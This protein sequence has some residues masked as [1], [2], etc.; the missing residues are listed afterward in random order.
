MES[1]AC[2]FD[3]FGLMTISHW[4]ECPNYSTGYFTAKT[5]STKFLSILLSTI[6]S[7]VQSNGKR[8]VG[9]LTTITCRGALGV[10]FTE[11]GRKS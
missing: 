2:S 7:R 8:I 9:F 5:Y 1:Q 4:L 10:G 3:K 11:A 6:S